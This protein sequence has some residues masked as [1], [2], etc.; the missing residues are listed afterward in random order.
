MSGPWSQEDVIQ[1]LMARTTPMDPWP[2]WRAVAATAIAIAMRSN[3]EAVPGG[4]VVIR[5]VPG[6]FE[7]EE[8]T[9]RG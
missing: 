8:R 3:A 5:V 7:L 1:W 6:G 4:L 2:R 9:G